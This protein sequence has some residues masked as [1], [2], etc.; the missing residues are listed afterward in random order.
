MYRFLAIIRN[1]TIL[2]ALYIACEGFYLFLRALPFQFKNSYK[3]LKSVRDRIIVRA[4]RENCEMKQKENENR[5]LEPPR[6]MT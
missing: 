5:H 3:D 1:Y 2:R 6:R 4:Y